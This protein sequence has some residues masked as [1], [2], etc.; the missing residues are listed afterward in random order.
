MFS[1]RFFANEKGDYLLGLRRICFFSSLERIVPNLRNLGVT[2][3]ST[4]ETFQD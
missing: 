2:K 1:W 3:Q 4:D